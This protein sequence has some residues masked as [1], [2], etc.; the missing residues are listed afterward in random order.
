MFSCQASGWLAE[1]SAKV[2]GEVTD[3]KRV[4]KS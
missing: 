1:L 2:P 4:N 3:D